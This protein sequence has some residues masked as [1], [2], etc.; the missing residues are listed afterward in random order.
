MKI[1]WNENKVSCKCIEKIF[2]PIFYV[3]FIDVLIDIEKYWEIIICGRIFKK[4]KEKIL[5]G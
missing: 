3:V 5:M 1:H 4:R 2:F